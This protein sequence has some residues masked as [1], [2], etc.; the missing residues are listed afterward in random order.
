M[1]NGTDVPEEFIELMDLTDFAVAFRYGEIEL[2]AEIDRPLLLKQV[3]RLVEAVESILREA[4]HPE[5]L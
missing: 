2:D 5:D 3:I 1:Q 4:E